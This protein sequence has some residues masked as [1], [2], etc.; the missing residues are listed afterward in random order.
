MIYKQLREYNLLY[1]S[2]EASRIYE[3]LLIIFEEERQY[4]NTY[5]IDTF[6]ALANDKG[7]IVNYSDI[8]NVDKD[9]KNIDNDDY[10]K[11]R[12]VKNIG[13]GLQSDHQQIIHNIIDSNFTDTD[14]INRL[15]YVIKDF[16]LEQILKN[17][18]NFKKSIYDKEGNFNPIYLRELIII[19]T[20]ERIFEEGDNLLDN[21]T[22]VR[23]TI[24]EK[25]I[26]EL[27]LYNKTLCV[28]NRYKKSHNLTLNKVSKKGEGKAFIT[29]V[30]LIL[31]DI[32]V[33]YETDRQK[34]R[35]KY[36]YMYTLNFYLLSNQILFTKEEEDCFRTDD[37]KYINIQIFLNEIIDNL[38]NPIKPQFI[39][40]D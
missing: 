25:K 34:G 26:I 33:S 2:Y 15:K 18:I 24:S 11:I 12:C 21:I 38:Y 36:I 39:E 7:N 16:Q 29:N 23:R 30:N 8:G 6:N 40:E 19:L 22:T 10:V 37:G 13:N 35:G 27:D 17:L 3:Y 1:I 9:Y 28:C 32:G 31:K 5:K 14:L 4:N 20:N